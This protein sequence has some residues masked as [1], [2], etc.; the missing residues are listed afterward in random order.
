M[1]ESLFAVAGFVVIV[2]YTIS[3]LKTPPLSLKAYTRTHLA[4][5]AFGGEGLEARTAAALAMLPK[6]K[7]IAF[8]EL[9]VLVQGEKQGI[10]VIHFLKTISRENKLPWWRVVRKKGDW[11]LLNGYSRNTYQSQLLQ[12]E[13]VAVAEDQTGQK[14]VNLEQWEWRE[15]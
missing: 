12:A 10:Q 8:S 7:V 5:L 11:G 15:E 4:S 1:M 14:Q 6:G 3:R 13:G 2:S 9:A